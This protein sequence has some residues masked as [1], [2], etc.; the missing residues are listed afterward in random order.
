MRP[1]DDEYEDLDE[2]DFDSF[3]ATHRM[4][5][6]KQRPH[7]KAAGRKHHRK[8]HKERWESD[9]SDRDDDYF[10]DEFDKYYGI[11]IKH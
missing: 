5:N 11:K 8:A 10:D 6:E 2:F 4:A 9:Y 7:H 1:F 3:E